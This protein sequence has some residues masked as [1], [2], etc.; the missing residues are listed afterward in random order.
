MKLEERINKIKTNDLASLLDKIIK[1]VCLYN[2]FIEFNLPFKESK[3]LFKQ[4]LISWMHDHGEQHSL[5]LSEKTV[6][7]HK[8]K[9]FD[10][11]Y[12]HLV[13]EHAL[14]SINNKL[15]SQASSKTI[16]EHMQTFEE[17]YLTHHLT[18][19]KGNL[20]QISSK[21]GVR[22]ETLSRKWNQIRKTKTL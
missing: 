18:P 13:S 19:K 10:V 2:H 8:N 6:Q 9:H 12:Q 5:Q 21:I 14:D 16:Q 17:V 20:T 3:R 22:R 4:R 15:L 7:R 11:P 1:N